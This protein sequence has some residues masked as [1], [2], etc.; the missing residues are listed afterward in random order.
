MFGR[1]LKK[2]FLIQPITL[3]SIDAKPTEH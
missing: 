1:A 2:S 3:Q